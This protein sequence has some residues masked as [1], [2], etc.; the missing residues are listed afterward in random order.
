MS[1]DL[2][3][4]MARSLLACRGRRRVQE[5][6]EKNPMRSTPVLVPTNEIVEIWRARLWIGG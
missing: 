1:G 3:K 6:Q 4:G 5:R 2:W